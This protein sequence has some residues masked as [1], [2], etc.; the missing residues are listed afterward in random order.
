MWKINS[1]MLSDT[2]K[3]S[4]SVVYAP[5][6]IKVLEGQ[7]VGV[8][9]S[10]TCL[11]HGRSINSEWKLLEKKKGTNMFRWLNQ[12]KEVKLQKSKLQKRPKAWLTIF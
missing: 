2:L 3:K 11:K 1:S 4:K 6:R 7:T 8:N 10:M 5:I 12:I 9:K